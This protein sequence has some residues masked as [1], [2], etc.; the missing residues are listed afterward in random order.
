FA[1][2]ARMAQYPLS[3]ASSAF[4]GP[5]RAK[6][7]R[8]ASFTDADRKSCP[9][10]RAMSA[11]ERSMKVLETGSSTGTAANPN[12]PAKPPEA[13]T[14]ILWSFSEAIVRGRFPKD[15]TATSSARIKARR[16]AECTASVQPCGNSLKPFSIGVPTRFAS[17]MASPGFSNSDFAV[18]KSCKS[19]ACSIALGNGGG[20]AMRRS[21]FREQLLDFAR[22]IVPRVQVP[23]ITFFIDEPH[24]GNA[25]D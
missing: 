5:P 3:E 24:R 16:A 15:A 2:A 17:R 1:S 8:H 10:L 11:I 9:S 22:E 6:T 4:E 25:A 20:T 21:V 14:R 19:F 7:S 13:P 12:A 23:Q 18:R